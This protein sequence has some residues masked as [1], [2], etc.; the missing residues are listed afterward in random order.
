[1]SV[2][3]IGAVYLRILKSRLLS[4][5]FSSYTALSKVRRFSH[6]C[7]RISAIICRNYTLALSLQVAKKITDGRTGKGVTLCEKIKR[8]C[9]IAAAFN[10]KK[11][12]L[13]VT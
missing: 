5:L 4:E 10:D 1:M 2:V 13:E 3:S 7:R 12:G 9:K 8:K 11:V 6:A